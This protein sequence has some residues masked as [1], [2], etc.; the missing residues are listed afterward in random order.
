MTGQNANDKDTDSVQVA[1]RA[2]DQNGNDVFHETNALPHGRRPAGA[3]WAFT[4]NEKEQNMA[5][6]WATRAT[7]P[8]NAVRVDVIVL[9]TDA[10]AGHDPVGGDYPIVIGSFAAT[11]ANGQSPW[12]VTN[13]P[14]DVFKPVRDRDQPDR[15]SRYAAEQRKT[16]AI[17]LGKTGYQM[18]PRDLPRANATSDTGFDI[19]IR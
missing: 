16:E 19:K 7:L 10:R 12:T 6:S 3:D 18:A 1:V 8:A 17:L 4:G 9:Y 14:G 5:A 2:Q 13:N 11:R 15:P